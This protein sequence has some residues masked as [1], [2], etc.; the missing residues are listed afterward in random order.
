MWNYIP[1]ESTVYEVEAI[2]QALVGRGGENLV[3]LARRH[4]RPHARH[5]VHASAVEVTCADGKAEH[6]V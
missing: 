3:L 6:L 2:H 5:L 1:D 4:V